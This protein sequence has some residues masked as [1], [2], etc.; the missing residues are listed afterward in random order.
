MCSV[1]VH[2]IRSLSQTGANVE[3]IRVELWL[4]VGL[5]F[6]NHSETVEWIQ[7]RLEGKKLKNNS[8]DKGGTAQATR[9]IA[10]EDSS[11][12]CEEQWLCLYL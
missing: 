6:A 7:D 12:A 9:E 2:L 10:D 4:H 1:T 3:Y 8:G 5:V 11:A